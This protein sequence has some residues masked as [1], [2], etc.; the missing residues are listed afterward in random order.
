[1]T[2]II[3]AGGQN[4]GPNILNWLLTESQFQIV[5][6]ILRTDDNGKDNTFP[7]L[8]KIALAHNIPIIAPRNVNTPDVLTFCKNSGATVLISAMYNQIFKAGIIN[9]FN[10]KNN[11][12]II[13]IHY[14][15]LPRYCG[16]WPEMHAIWEQEKNFAL[17][18]HYI[19]TGIDTG[20]VLYQPAV[21]IAANETRQSLYQKCDAL[22]LKTF[23]EHA[24]K[25]LA[26]KQPAT[27]QDITRKTYYKRN[28]PNDGILDLNWDADTQS[29]FLRAT[30]FPPY[31]NAK[32][33]LNGQVY[34]LIPTDIP[35]G[36]KIETPQ[37]D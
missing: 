23:Q 13:N 2:K 7:S 24:T 14:A 27:P 37:N 3:I 22:A 1:M 17:T 9:Y 15:P 12:G 20:D 19:N 35:F 10:A 11:A 18:F 29:R 5:G 8:K 25:F 28:L 21:N 30:H 4:L 33:N 26:Q 6:I 16:F 31:L 34:S 36:S 32:I